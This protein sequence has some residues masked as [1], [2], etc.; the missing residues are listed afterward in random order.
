M[1][2][3]KAQPNVAV[4]NKDQIKSIF[5]FLIR[6]LAPLAL[7]L[8]W[9]LISLSLPNSPRY[10]TPTG[11]IAA[12]KDLWASGDFQT[13]SL[14]SIKHVFF[15]FVFA[16]IAGGILGLVM[17]Y[18]NTVNQW[19][20]PFV[21][22]LRPIAPYA[23][24]PLAI[25]W[26]GIGDTTAFVIVAYA[27]FFPMLINAITGARNLD[28]NLINAARCLGA[29]PLTI[30][31][32]VIFPA[33]LPYLLVGARLAMGSAWISVVAAELATGA[34]GG[35]SATGGLGQMMFVFYAY[36]TNLNYIVVCIIGVGVF[37]L[38]SDR[39]LHWFYKV[40]TPWSQG[41]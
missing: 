6:V 24:I 39:L 32:R 13:G 35:Q 41:T 33:T 11:V 27:A 20:G 26:F 2:E 16:T 30:F 18:S 14:V 22:S 8:V 40:L 12:F 5:L 7:I 19:L 15:S 1:I 25:L 34:R 23:W 31:R 17:G 10:A 29:S 4:W 38:L 28:R 9:Y 3:A 37:S 21:H 36:Y